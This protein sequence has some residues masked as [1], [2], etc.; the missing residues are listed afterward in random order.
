M[1]CWWHFLDIIIWITCYDTVRFTWDVVFG[2]QIGIIINCKFDSNIWW[3]EGV[4]ASIIK[5]GWNINFIYS[6]CVIKVFEADYITMGWYVVSKLCC[7]KMPGFIQTIILKCTL[8]GVVMHIENNLKGNIEILQSLLKVLSIFNM[9]I[10][11]VC[12]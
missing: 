4:K 1:I 5:I 9:S 6:S 12:V 8:N 11:C 2:I 10:W 3:E 7:V